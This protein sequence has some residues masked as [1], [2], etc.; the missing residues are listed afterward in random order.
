MGAFL[1]AF[2][3]NHYSSRLQMIQDADEYRQI[4]ATVNEQID[5]GPIQVYGV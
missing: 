4:F 1:S 2:W 3:E 5:K